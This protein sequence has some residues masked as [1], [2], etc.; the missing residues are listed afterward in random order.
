MIRLAKVKA[1]IEKE[2]GLTGQAFQW[3]EE[4]SGIDLS[5]AHLEDPIA[6]EKRK[7][8]V[9]TLP[10][11]PEQ[12]YFVYGEHVKT[13]QD[14]NLLIREGNQRQVASETQIDLCKFQAV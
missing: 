5:Q 8:I 10:H 12:T 9:S 13:E 7:Q 14:L 4:H 11:L 2:L 6:S 3:I 1:L